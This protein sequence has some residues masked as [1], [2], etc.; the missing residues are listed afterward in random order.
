MNNTVQQ[1]DPFITAFFGIFYITLIVIYFRY[2]KSKHTKKIDE[3][4][5]LPVEER[6]FQLLKLQG[7]ST[8]YKTNHILHL[9]LTLFML[10]LWIIPWFFIAQS[11][12]AKRSEIDKLIEEM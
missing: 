9:L 10:G 11:N 6:K 5:K 1:A 7:K 2:K 3:L 8:K 12:S 4:R